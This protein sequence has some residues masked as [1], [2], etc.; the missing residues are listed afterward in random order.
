MPS[1]CCLEHLS[2]EIVW[3]LMILDEMWE[4]PDRLQDLQHDL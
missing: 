4:D 1:R 3:D 2:L